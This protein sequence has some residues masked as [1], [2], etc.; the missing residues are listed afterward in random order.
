MSP[1]PCAVCYLQEAQCKSTGPPLPSDPQDPHFERV[2]QYIDQLIANPTAIFRCPHLHIEAHNT[3]NKDCMQTLQNLWS[4][5]EK[6]RAR[7][8]S[9]EFFKKYNITPR[10]DNVRT[11][12]S[13]EDELAEFAVLVEVEE[14][15][16]M[17]WT[18]LPGAPEEVRNAWLDYCQ[19][20]FWQRHCV[21]LDKYMEEQRAIIMRAAK[22]TSEAGWRAVRSGKIAK[23]DPMRGLRPVQKVLWRRCGKWL[24][25][26]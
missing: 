10:V 8:T 26:I 1:K 2:V 23:L 14:V 7:C 20:W 21:G 19:P 5:V 22:E 17:A 18:Y 24:L 25:R 3:I 11:N 12:K 4:L 6:Q 13:Q 15:P 16:S 9:P